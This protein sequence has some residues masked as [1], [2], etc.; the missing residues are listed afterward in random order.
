[1]DQLIYLQKV[2]QANMSILMQLIW[3]KEAISRVELVQLSNLTSGTVTNLTQELLQLG[4]IREFATTS[5]T[6]G[7]KRV[8]LK[9]NTEGYMIIGIDIGRTSYE[10]ILTDLTGR[11][12]K[13]AGGNTVGIH[14]P[15][16]IMAMLSPHI[17]QMKRYAA[18]RGIPV[19]GAGASIPGPI[20][21]R[22]GQ[23][24]EPPNFPGWQRYP[25]AERL[26]A[27]TGLPV[28]IDDDARTSALAERWFGLGR[29]VQNML[30]VTLGTGIGGGVINNGRL[31]EGAHGLFG[32]VGHI[33]IDPRGDRCACG[34]IGCWET[35]G[36]IPAILRKWSKP[37]TIDDFFLAA[38]IGDPAAVSCLGEV[39]FWLETAL[40][41]L[42]NTYD[43]EMIVLGGRLYPYLAMYMPSI[44]A[45]VRARAYAFVRDSLSIEQASFGASQSATGAASLVFEQL[46]RHPLQMLAAE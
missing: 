28:F 36:S 25:I 10:V 3:E 43:P 37:G 1:M 26:S 9:W 41:T 21:Y 35:V 24:L 2:K 45:N 40:T 18:S 34:N 44:R 27:L 33:T 39:L 30:F 12:I 15:E 38:R 46:L 20:D 16:A 29:T 8:L 14:D 5:S 31:M 4:L 6:I 32:H 19:L 11:V 13:S 42:F 17:E 23:L 7:R 22:L